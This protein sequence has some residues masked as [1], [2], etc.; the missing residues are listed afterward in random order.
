MLDVKI[1]LHRHYLLADAPNQKLF[2][3]LEI[4]SDKKCIDS[5]RQ[6]FSAVFAVDTSGSMRE[7]AV[8]PED[9]TVANTA[10]GNFKR[11]GKAAYGKTKMDILKDALIDLYGSPI[12]KRGDRLSLVKFDDTARVLLPFT[13]ATDK[14]A[15][16]EA[17][18]SLEK[19]SGGTNMGAGMKTALELLGNEKGNTRMF[20]FTDGNTIDEDLALEMSEEFARNKIPITAIGIGNDWNTDFIAL[21]VGRTHGKIFH[22]LADAENGGYPSDVNTGELKSILMSELKHSVN[23]TVTNIVLN[24][25]PA[26]EVKIDR[27]SRVYPVQ[28]E[29]DLSL[30]PFFLGNAEAGNITVF[31]IEMTV[32]EHKPGKMRLSQ[33]SLTHDV[34]GASYRG[35]TPIIEVTVEFGNNEGSVSSTNKEVMHYMQQRNIDSMIDKAVGEVRNNANKAVEI[36]K[37]A[38]RTAVILNNASMTRVLDKAVKELQDGKT[39]NEGTLKA[40]KVG[41]KTHTVR[42]GKDIFTDEEIKKITGA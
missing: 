19:Y 2:V 16:T 38:M 13:D 17:V 25:S 1:K 18:N 22:A 7:P 41:A 10:A 8:K 32:P 3:L 9:I 23:E 24:I 14:K 26:R 28:S 40:L 29:V 12:L 30:K 21:L 42:F 27:I 11:G 20:L 34:C 31:L 33:V 35:E 15:L 6:E 39:I 4:S 37:A 5:E 36:L